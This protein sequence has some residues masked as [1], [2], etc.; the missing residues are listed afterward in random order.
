MASFIVQSIGIENLHVSGSLL[1]ASETG[2]NIELG[3]AVSSSPQ[4]DRYA[5]CSK[6]GANQAERRYR[7]DA[8][9]SL[10]CMGE[11]AC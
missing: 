3:I 2:R 11:P 10:P 1:H 9:G 4:I 6:H 8:P 7:S 5:V